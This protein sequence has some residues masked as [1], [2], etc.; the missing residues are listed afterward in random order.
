MSPKPHF[1]LHGGFHKTASTHI[2]S[3]LNRNKKKLQ[4]HGITYVHHR[5]TRKKLTVPCQFHVYQQLGLNF[6][7]KYSEEELKEISEKYFEEVLSGAGAR[8]IISDENMAG[9]CGHCVK[10]GLLYRWRNRLLRT[11][12]QQFP[13]PVAEVH[14]AVRNY[15]DFFSAAYVEFLRS[16]TSQNFL[17]VSEMKIRVLEHMPSWYKLILTVGE[18]FPEARINVWKYE[19]YRALEKQ[20]FANLCGPD[21]DLELLEPPADKNRR[22]TA[23]GR[24]V[25][26]VLKLIYRHGADYALSR[27]VEIQEQFPKSA[28]NGVFDPWTPSERAHLTRMYE[29]DIDDIRANP[30]ITLIEPGQV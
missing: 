22:P 11:F 3:T 21:F 2:Q 16:S 4:R 6:E 9:H 17:D 30:D 28:E 20:V 27:R 26:E 1:I 15:A 12:A 8:I 14:L 10:R 24:A 25:E 23:S 5:D 13:F 19:D 7:I 18:N 29:R